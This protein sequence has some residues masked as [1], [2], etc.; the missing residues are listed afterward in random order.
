M[1][2]EDVSIVSTRTINFDDDKEDDDDCI[3]AIPSIDKDKQVS[4]VGTISKITISNNANFRLQKRHRRERSNRK[5][6][7]IGEMF[8]NDDG[9][10]TVSLPKDKP[11]SNLVAATD[12]LNISRKR[13]KSRREGKIKMI[14]TLTTVA[15]PNDKEGKRARKHPRRKPK[16][17]VSNGND[18]IDIGSLVQ[19]AH[20]AL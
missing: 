12:G 1:T 14:Q 2:N 17:E 9:S 16:M 6:E 10:K 11:E 15:K 20:I 3:S 18:D 19:V 8:E 7:S 5:E 13:R 4:S